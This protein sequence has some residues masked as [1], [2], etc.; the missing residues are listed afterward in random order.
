[1]II[2][3]QPLALLF[4]GLG[5]AQEDIAKFASR[6]MTFIKECRD[7]T[8]CNHL[9]CESGALMRTAAPDITMRNT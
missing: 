8:L 2:L 7:E 6:P 4:S 3:A 9:D 1:M 5:H